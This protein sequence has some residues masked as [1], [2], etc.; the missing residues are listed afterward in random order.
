MARPI[1][2]PSSEDDTRKTPL[3][4]DVEEIEMMSEDERKWVN[5]WKLD[6]PS[7]KKL[8]ELKVELGL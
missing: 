4:D 8:L 3:V 5:G 6:E 1:D 7:K 2:A